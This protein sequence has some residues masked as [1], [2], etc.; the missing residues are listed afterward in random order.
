MVHQV[1]VVLTDAIAINDQLLT[2]IRLSTIN[3]NPFVLQLKEAAFISEP[4]SGN[5]DDIIANNATGNGYATNGV[6]SHF[7]H[8][9]E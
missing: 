6:R 1:T 2:V 5:D 3:N 8:S 7:A 9:V 4:D